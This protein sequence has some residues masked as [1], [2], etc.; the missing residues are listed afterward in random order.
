MD[1]WE[2]GVRSAMSC[3]CGGHFCAAMDFVIITHALRQS[4][5]LESSDA[6]LGILGF[7]ENPIDKTAAIVLARLGRVALWMDLEAT[8][9]NRSILKT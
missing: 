5:A 6:G 8:L 7:L 9:L 3:Q 1:L 4:A 2:E